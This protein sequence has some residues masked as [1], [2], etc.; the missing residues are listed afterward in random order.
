MTRPEEYYVAIARTSLLELLEKE[1]AVV[2]LEI[3]AKLTLPRAGLP[4]GINPHI[5]TVARRELTQSGVLQSVSEPT[6]GS[7][8]ITV[9]GFRNRQGRE[10][11]FQ[12]AAQR[13]R[14]LMAR[15]LGWTEDRPKRRSPVGHAGEIVSHGSLLDAAPNGYKLVQPEGSPIENLFGA[16]VPGGALDDAAYLQ[17]VSD[18]GMPSGTVF[19]PIEVKNIREWLYPNGSELYQLLDKA[20]RLR[21]E[22]PQLPIA[23]VLVCRRASY[24]ATRMAQQMGFFIAQTGNQF[25]R[26]L[27]EV[28]EDEGRLLREVQNELGFHD[29][30]AT[31]SPHFALTRLLV[32]S[33][34]AV[35]Q[36]TADRFAASAP[37]IA[38]YSGALRTDTLRFGE[39]EEIMERLREDV[40]ELDTFDPERSW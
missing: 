37:I 19:V 23:P 38:R 32:N 20:A 31:E 6:R 5:L 1:H 18:Q 14:L 11:V 22:Y 21:A 33:L 9:I 4:T 13:K 29:L 3:E 26:P 8:T 12:E 15:Y 34:P 24:F 40:A 39:R 2:S 27:E 35:A 25:I 16:P 10:T 30:I 17:L 36:R 28:M 7:R